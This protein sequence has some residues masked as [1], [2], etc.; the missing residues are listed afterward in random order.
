[1]T[2]S[3]SLDL[4]KERA[5]A[6]SAQVEEVAGIS[7]ALARAVELTR[8]E[9]GRAL[10]AAGLSQDARRELAGLCRD[11]GVELVSG[12]LR[13]A[14]ERL[15]T[16]LTP[17]LWGVAE[18]GTIIMDCKEEEWRLA[19]MLPLVQVALLPADRIVPELES[20]ADEL[21]GL[22]AQGPDYLAFI[23]GPSRT[24]DIERVLTIGVHG[25]ARL[26]LLILPEGAP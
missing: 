10:A 4:F 2:A 19:T 23:T 26:H 14:A 20:I 11:A 8:A 1:M 13:E 15:H 24:A 12:D 18:T 6:V 17:A 16:G 5:R 9:G 21:A 7:P 3:S 25:P 22:M